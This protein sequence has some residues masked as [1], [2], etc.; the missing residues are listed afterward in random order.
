M[1]FNYGRQTISA[2][3]LT[4]VN[5]V[6]KSDFL[7]Q[8][9]KILEF[10][11]ALAKKFKASHCAVVSSGTAALHLAG[12]ALGWKKNDYII[13][14]PITFLASTN[15]I[16]YSGANPDFVDININN[17]TIDCNKLEE[18]VIKLKKKNKNVKAV[19]GVDYAGHPCDWKSLRY[20]ANKYDFQLINDNC[21][22]MGSMIDKN[23]GYAIKFADIVT[24]SYHPV[25]QITT[26]EGGAIFLK[27]QK[28]FKRIE[29]LRTH[30][31]SRKNTEPWLYEMKE[32]G[33]NYRMT[34]IQ[35]A[36]G[37]SQLKR[38]NN[39]VLK[40]NKI[41]KIYNSKFKEIEDVIIP[42][43]DKNIFHSYHLYP[44]Q[45]N[46]KKLKIKK[47]SFFK[48]ILRKKIKLQV[49]YIPIFLQ[50]YYKKKFNYNAKLFDNS[51]S[52]YRNQCS[53]PIYPNLKISEVQKVS[54]II[55]NEIKKK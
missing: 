55:I 23:I 6:L 33:F 34:D 10:E 47:N 50:P 54:K 46:F 8:G 31:I 35:A 3:D 49:H 19:I 5:K 12:I 53:L 40:R 37:I 1:I 11:K 21:H 4:A 45:I 39:F 26:G 30:G 15:A 7:T 9:P 25:K 18:R 38:L 27:D 20:L 48:N 22:A 42:K 36:L 44:L 43:I 13:S 17:Y 51:L 2:E 32:L 29:R 41:A 16:L 24:Q 52:F 28:L 14:S